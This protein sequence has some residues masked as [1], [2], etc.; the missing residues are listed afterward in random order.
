MNFDQPIMQKLLINSL[1]P[2]DELIIKTK[3][4]RY[5]FKIIDPFT[6][7]GILSGGHLGSK[8]CRAVLLYTL[9]SPLATV[10]NKV[11]KINAKVL[12]LVEINSKPTHL[13]TSPIT[14]LKVIRFV[15]NWE[16]QQLLKAS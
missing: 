5:Q 11:I 2:E 4:S 15:D 12:F 14:Q 16:K 13:C 3:N 7:S 1:K 6:S 8:G 10:D 9:E